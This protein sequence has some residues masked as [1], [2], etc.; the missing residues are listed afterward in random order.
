MWFLFRRKDLN[1]SLRDSV[2]RSP[3]HVAAQAGAVQCLKLLLEVHSSYYEINNK[4]WKCFLILGPFEKTFLWISL[5][6]ILINIKS[7]QRKNVKTNL[8]CHLIPMI[9]GFFLIKRNFSRQFLN[10]N[11]IQFCSNEL[12]SHLTFLISASSELLNSGL[13]K[14]KDLVQLI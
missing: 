10:C 11:K 4:L 7:F 5:S 6:R 2:G 1:R 8:I 9:I 14:L 13:I 12:K 3:V